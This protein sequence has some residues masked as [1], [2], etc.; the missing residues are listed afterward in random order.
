MNGE[1]QDKVLW[2]IEH[3]IVIALGLAGLLGGAVGFFGLPGKVEANTNDIKT[4]KEY[5]SRNEV[6]VQKMAKDV[7]YINEKFVGLEKD[8][9]EIL[10]RTGD[11]GG[12]ER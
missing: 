8:I 7:Q 10:R 6:Y 9:K 12:A 3:L 1:S 11:Y 2:R 4:M 5:M